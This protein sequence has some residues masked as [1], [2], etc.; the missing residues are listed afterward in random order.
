MADDEGMGSSDLGTAL[1][2]LRDHLIGC[3]AECPPDKAAPLA[4]RLESVL[5]RLDAMAAPEVSK[6]D[7][8]AAAR[9]KR[10]TGS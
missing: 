9:R 4:A 7:E 2:A 1:R 6:V 3:L 5:I 8:L 10:R